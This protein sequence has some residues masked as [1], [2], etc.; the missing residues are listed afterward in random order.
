M[1]RPV[2]C[3]TFALNWYVGQDD[4]F[5]FHVVNIALHILTAFVLYP[6]YP[7]ALFNPGSAPGIFTGALVCSP[8][9]RNPLGRQ[10]HP[11]PGGHLHRTA[12]GRYGRILLSGRS[13]CIS[14]GKTFQHS[15]CAPGRLRSL[16]RVL[17]SGSRVQGEYHCPTPVV[18]PD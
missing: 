13:L 6:L 1:Y 10:P 11:Y 9:G 2:P 16:P 12:D 14:K 18:D 17:Y 5:G 4:P 15:P 8:A 7:D 3:L